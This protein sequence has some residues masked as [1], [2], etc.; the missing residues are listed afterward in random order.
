[1]K[2]GLYAGIEAKPEHAQQVETMLRNAAEL[3]KQSQTIVTWFSLRE[4]PTTLADS[5]AFADEQ[6]WGARLEGRIADASLYAAQTMLARTPAIM[7]VDTKRKYLPLP[8]LLSG[9]GSIAPT[10]TPTRLRPR[11]RT[12]RSLPISRRATKV[13]ATKPTGRKTYPPRA[14][15]R[16]TGHCPSRCGSPSHSK[17]EKGR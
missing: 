1:M 2:L 5:D 3:V 15:S 8:E 9:I 17:T 7:R 4:N 6:G 10:T 14:Y 11:F 12:T 13:S 16:L